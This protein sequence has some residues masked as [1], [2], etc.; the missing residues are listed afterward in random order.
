MAIHQ[1]ERRAAQADD[2]EL[3]TRVRAILT[4]DVGAVRVERSAMEDDRRGVDFWAYL[5]GGNRVG[6]DL[7]A[8][9]RDWGDVYVELVS[10]SAE[11]KPGWTVNEKYITDYVLFLFPNRHLLLPYPQLRALVRRR[12]ATYRKRYGTTW[13]KSRGA[14]MDWQ[15]ENCAIPEGLLFYEMFGISIPGLA[16]TKPRLCPGGCG[17][18]HPVGTTCATGWAPWQPSRPD[19]EAEIAVDEPGVEW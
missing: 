13:A 12:E 11:Q 19:M 16:L 2:P 3:V 1:F 4:A 10:R 7:K 18:S 9:R 15:T 6:V 8:R 14:S 5:S 17:E